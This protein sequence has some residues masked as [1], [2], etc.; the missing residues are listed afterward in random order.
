MSRRDPDEHLLREA[1]VT[2]IG[3][4]FPRLCEVILHG[5]RRPRNA[6][7]VAESDLSARQLGDAAT[8][9]GAA[10]SRTQVAQASS[11]PQPAPGPTAVQGSTSIARDRHVAAI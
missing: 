9:L 3:R 6:I 7:R 8:E 4:M 1:V 2:R 11:R 5:M 10:E